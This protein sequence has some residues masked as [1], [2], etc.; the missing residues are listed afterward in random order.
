MLGKNFHGI[1]SYPCFL[2]CLRHITPSMLNELC[3]PLRVFN[4]CFGNLFPEFPADDSAMASEGQA[5][6]KWLF[7]PFQNDVPKLFKCEFVRN[8]WEDWPLKI[9]AFKAAFASASSPVN[10]IVSIWFLPPFTASV[11]PFDLTNEL[12][13]EQ[14]TLKRMNNSQPNGQNGKRKRLAGNFN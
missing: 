14:L 2:H 5:V 1:E 12:T 11:V 6:A 3:P 8:E 13:R 7:T 4:A 9:D 10:F